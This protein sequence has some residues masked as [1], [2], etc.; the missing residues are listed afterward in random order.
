MEDSAF[1]HVYHL[2]DKVFLWFVVF[3]GL[4]LLYQSYTGEGRG[5]GDVFNICFSDFF[6]FNCSLILYLHNIK[7]LVVCIDICV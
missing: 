2:F 3:L 1:L 6:S 5:V 7:S 4:L